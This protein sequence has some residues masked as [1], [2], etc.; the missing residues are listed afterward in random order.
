MGYEVEI[1][2]RVAKLDELRLRL[3][4]FG[5]EPEPAIAQEDTYFAH[6]SRDFAQT[7]EALRLRREGSINRITYKGPKHAGPTKTRE[8]IEIRFNDGSDDYEAMVRLLQNLGFSSVA[9]I[10]KLRT[11]YHVAWDGRMIEVVLDQSA[12]L[13]DFAEV[14]TLALGQADLPHAQQAV[15]RVAAELGLKDI[16]PRSYLRMTLSQMAD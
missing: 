5:T 12:R 6:P 2:F 14:E 11:T 1:K 3:K 9:T 15:L 8:E 10:R 4:A 13:G 16:E 7:D